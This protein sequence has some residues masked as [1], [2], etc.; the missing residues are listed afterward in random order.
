M[1]LQQFLEENKIKTYDELVKKCSS[2]KNCLDVIVPSQKE[3]EEIT[4]Q[5]PTPA[6]V[7]VVKTVPTKIEQLVMDVSITQPVELNV[8]HSHDTESLREV[9]AK[10]ENESK[11]Q[12]K[13]KSKTD[14]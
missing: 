3:F 11:K 4:N 13:K 14:E 10:E 1:S 5:A 7:V 9:D 6:L 8:G 12:S 2:G